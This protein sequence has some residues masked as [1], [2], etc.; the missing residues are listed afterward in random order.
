MSARNMSSVFRFLSF[1]TREDIRA[2]I[3]VDA[4]EYASNIENRLRSLGENELADRMLAEIQE[5]TAED[6]D[7]RRRQKAG[8]DEDRA[9]GRDPLPWG[10]Y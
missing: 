7:F 8:I 3:T 4:D 10:D 5:S 6:A 2:L 1:G 9:I